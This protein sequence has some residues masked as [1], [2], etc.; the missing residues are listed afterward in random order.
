[1]ILFSASNVPLFRQFVRLLGKKLSRTLFSCTLRPRMVGVPKTKI[2]LSIGKNGRRMYSF[3]LRPAGIKHVVFSFAQK[4]YEEGKIQHASYCCQP[5]GRRA[6][7]R[8]NTLPQ[9]LKNLSKPA[10]YYA[11]FFLLPKRFISSV[12]RYDSQRGSTN[13]NKEEEDLLVVAKPEQRLF[14]K[15]IFNAQRLQGKEID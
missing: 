10:I 8:S 13:G 4:N 11:K 5:K 14:P 9:A 12:H 7:L 15:T 1:M 3:P 2:A 6:L